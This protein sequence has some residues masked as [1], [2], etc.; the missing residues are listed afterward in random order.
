MRCSINVPNFGDFADPA[1]FA[2]L[3]RTA[4]DAGW[5]AL[6]VWDHVLE[7]KTRRR[8]IADPWILLAAAATA[9]RRLR[10]GTMITPVPRRRPQ[11]LA[12]EVTTLDRL[13]G[14][15][16]ILGVGLGAP[17]EDEYATFGEPDDAR[18]LARR[19]DE[20]LD[21]LAAAWSGGPVDYEGE[22]VTVRDATFLPTPVQRPRVPIWVGGRWP[23]RAPLRRAARWDGSIPLMTGGFDAVPSP[24]DEVRDWHDT[25]R[26]MRAE[27]GREDEPF[28]FVVGGATE[29]ATAPDVVGPLADAGATWWDERVPFHDG[30][31]D[32][33]D[34]IR[35][36]VKQ[37][38]PR[39]DRNA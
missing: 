4:E 6:F 27:A 26:A 31:F 11:K 35:R 30:V 20:S 2:E 13:S 32:R 18:V 23:H 7:E 14:G 3:A 38:P 28:E 5:D 34:P 15:R 10:L 22:H 1:T 19:L 39:I 17:L 12:R 36:R 24:L 9:T 33:L 8:H 16:T 37:G 29:P 25:V 21:V